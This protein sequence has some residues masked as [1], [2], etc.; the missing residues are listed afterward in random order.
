M[1]SMVVRGR[2]VELVA[3]GSVTGGGVVSGGG[4]TVVAGGRRTGTL[5]TT[6]RTGVLGGGNVVATATVTVAV[7]GLEVGT[8]VRPRL[9]SRNVMPVR[10]I[11]PSTVVGV[12]VETSVLP[13]DAPPTNSTA[14]A[15]IDTTVNA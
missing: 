10:E 4:A 11:A 8:T 5:V 1:G 12:A 9:R 2:L 13:M 6:G 7:A 3:A 15:S 14:R